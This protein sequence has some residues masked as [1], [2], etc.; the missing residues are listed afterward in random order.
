MIKKQTSKIILTL[1]LYFTVSWWVLAVSKIVLNINLHFF[2]LQYIS[3][4]NN[5]LVIR[6][7]FQDGF[8][9]MSVLAHTRTK[10]A[11]HLRFRILEI[12]FVSLFCCCFVV[13]YWT[14]F[15]NRPPTVIQ[16]NN[17]VFIQLRRSPTLEVSTQ[18]EY[19]CVPFEFPSLVQTCPTFPFS[20]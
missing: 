17:A 18:T 8:K 14:D 19:H 4:N 12:R 2:Q 11:G 5:W 13:V 9:S 16:Y 7:F 10:Y 3:M 20:S 6:N 1:G 15:H